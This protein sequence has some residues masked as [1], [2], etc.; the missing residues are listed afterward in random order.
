MNS[1]MMIIDDSI[2]ETSVGVPYSSY[3]NTIN[4]G[5]SHFNQERGSV[6]TQPS[7]F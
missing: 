7:S 3:S 5:R 2:I 1:K 6:G 4:T